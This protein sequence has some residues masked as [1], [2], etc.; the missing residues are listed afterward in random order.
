M[1]WDPSL[2]LC[3]HTSADQLPAFQPGTPDLSAVAVTLPTPTLSVSSF[4]KEVF[5]LNKD[6]ELVSF[7]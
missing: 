1:M 6:R 5:P 7:R 4:R 2:V 3:F